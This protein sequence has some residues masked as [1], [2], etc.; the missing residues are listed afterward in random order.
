VRGLI[1]RSSGFQP[2][3]STISFTDLGGSEP[4]Q[5]VRANTPF[6]LSSR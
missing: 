4:C 1:T 3:D 2:L 5:G 6:F